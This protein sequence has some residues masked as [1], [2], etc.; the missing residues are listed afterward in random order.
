MNT[1]GTIDWKTFLNK[2][3]G[4]MSREQEDAFIA[5]ANF[6]SSGKETGENLSKRTGQAEAGTD[7]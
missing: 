1:K 6:I 3:T 5:K 4:K 7:S 2:V